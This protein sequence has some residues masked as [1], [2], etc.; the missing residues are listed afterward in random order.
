[1]VP[2]PLAP[3]TDHRAAIR[4][5]TLADETV[6]V[7]ALADQARIDAAGQGRAHGEARDLV[8]TLRENHAPGLTEAL[9]AEYGLSQPEGVALMCLAEAVLRVPDT[10]SLDALIRDKIAPA[11][12]R[13][14]A[15]QAPS[16][17]INAATWGLTRAGAL[18]RGDDA[19]GT[20]PKTVLQAPLRRLGTPVIRAAVVEAMKQMGRHFVLG[21][22]I[23]EAMTR[24][25]PLEARGYT[26]SYDMLGEAARTMADADRYYESYRGALGR[27]ATV[28]GHD[29]VGANPGISIKLSSLHPRFEPMQRARCLPVVVSRVGH[30]ARLARDANMG[31][32]VDA[33]EQ[34]R[35]DLTLDVIEAVLSNSDLA[36]WDGLGVVVQSYGPRM[37]P[38][39]DWVIALA[40]HL[41]RRV[42]VR[43]V[44][45]AYWDT[46]IKRAQVLG[47]DGYPVFT[48]KASS[49]VAYL[50]GARRL[51]ARPDRVFPQFA[52]HNARTM[53]D[54]LER[55]G[56]GAR[57]EFQ[58]LHGMGEALHDLVRARHG[59][60]CR[61]YAP[62]GH[63]ADLLA[64]LVRRMLEN[65]ANS[66]FVHQ[67]LDPA[68]PVDALA[69]DPLAIA[70]A[71][72]PLPHP[73]IRPPP[74]L[75]GAARRNSRGLDLTDP[76]ARAWF[77][78]ERAPFRAHQW[79]AH[80]LIGDERHPGRRRPVVN[81]ADPRDSVGTVH[82]ADPALARVAV[83]T[84]LA[85]L[86]A[87]SDQPV[88]AR[89]AILERASDLYEA[90]MPALMALAT[91]EAGKTQADAVGEVRE[92]VDFLRYYAAEARALPSGRAPR[93]VFVCIS[94]WNFPLA[95]FIG[96]VAAALVT[97]NAVIAKPAE[98]TCLMAA[99][100]VALLRE[101]G[102]PAGALALL[103]GDGA[104]VGGALTADD[105]I[106]GVCFTGSGETAQAIH[107]AM[108]ERGAAAAPL[109]AETGGL[110]AMI[111]DSTALPEQVV[112]D[113]LASAFQSAGQRCSALRLLCLQ[114]DIA[115]RTLA[116]LRGAMDTLAVGDPW[117][118]ATDVGPVIDAEAR[119]DIMAHVT[120]L[121]AEGRLVHRAPPPAGASSGRF[122]APAV[123]R[124][125]R[126]ED[127]TREVFGPV[128][129]VVTWTA[130][131]LD[132]LVTRI[133]ALGYGLT[134]GLHSRMEARAARVGAV[135]R[136]GNVYVNRNQIGA[137]VGVQPFGG[138][139]L[140][141]T[142][143]KA[144]GPHYLLRFTRAVAKG[145][146]PPPSAPIINGTRDV[147]AVSDALA[148]AA[149]EM[150]AWSARRDRVAMLRTVI[151][152]LPGA[153]ADAATAG[154]A[155]ADPLDPGPA[156]LPGP[157]GE[158]NQFSL[159]PRGV[160]LC[161][162]D[163][164]DAPAPAI[165]QAVT[166]LALGCAVV[167]PDALLAALRS[168][169]SLM[170]VPLKTL[171]GW[172]ALDA[173]SVAAPLGLVALWHASKDNVRPLRRA[174]AKRPGPLV[175]MA[176]DPD[177]VAAFVIERTLS[178]DTTASG[179]N[180]TLLARMAKME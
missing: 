155:A 178:T 131:D 169:L 10:P 116:M 121:E 88:T 148:A 2:V 19:A 64:Y 39:L 106:G 36:G 30:L 24:A 147:R 84:A 96:Q 125:D 102:V 20:V 61:I 133:N 128:L 58:R 6:S 72:D 163:G 17:L 170:P 91:R 123:V 83:D 112:R 68:V 104:S 12:W 160:V 53:A 140:S 46:E 59:L 126:L 153:D 166:A 164:A 129:H 179:G 173:L 56:E 98:Q 107:R 122:V 171:A 26:I 21:R 154:L 40:D 159:Q 28:A 51:L 63:H 143:P 110:N 118:V 93:G 115:D 94:P 81:P 45:G 111:V 99:R 90:H 130:A 158:R 82:D 142:G 101:A 48:R 172:P 33:E 162:G 176:D 35:L 105:R 78:T 95:I 146:D 135:A 50:A 54:V 167:G 74:S 77:E 139:G 18:L 134:L 69:R 7:R 31:L 23:D 29:D 137:V 5:A 156:E 32:T 49:D 14:H 73:A 132:A 103:P 43:L 168:R 136:V 41:D 109:I 180:T 108:A 145:D 97:G 55:A 1:M 60:P 100:A 47:L 113:V 177:D 9:L 149:R 92:A 34:E 117:D 85:A 152:D 124:L 89:A 76:R 87:W 4:A 174:L 141:G 3:L 13:R 175:A 44:K 165:R 57:F 138:E 8:Q 80:P 27:L 42:T 66:S 161:L 120:A 67:V 144:G 79:E 119:A 11:D 15:G 22:T 37:G 25:R 86:P 157:T 52:T 65:G 150:P 62:V 75:Y 16:A 151:A 38:V 70:D 127:L 114:E 71:L